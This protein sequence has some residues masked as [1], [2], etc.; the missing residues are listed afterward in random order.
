MIEHVK[1]KVSADDSHEWLIDEDT[2]EVYIFDDP[3]RARRPV[4]I[5]KEGVPLLSENHLKRCTSIF[6][7]KRFNNIWKILY[8][9]ISRSAIR[10]G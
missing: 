2:N 9:V 3:G 10:R 1:L 4:I 7:F 8:N 6:R 5:V